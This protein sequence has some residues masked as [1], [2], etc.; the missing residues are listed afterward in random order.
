MTITGAQIKAARQLLGW[1][2]ATLSAE[3]RVSTTAISK[4]EQGGR[5]PPLLPC[6][7]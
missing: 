5:R 7:Q 6:P 3:V 2:Q 4:F 1:T